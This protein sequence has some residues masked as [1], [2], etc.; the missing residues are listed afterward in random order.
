MHHETAGLL[1]IKKCVM[2]RDYL[3]IVCSVWLCCWL[4][5]AVSGG[6]H[7]V[8]TSCSLSIA[9]GF[10]NRFVIDLYEIVFY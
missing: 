4:M 3:Y 10:G 5:C 9:L 1:R 6:K 8:S 7:T 2:L